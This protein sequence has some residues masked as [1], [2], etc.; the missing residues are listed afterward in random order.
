MSK[1]GIEEKETLDTIKKMNMQGIILNLA[2]GDGRFNNHLLEYADKVIAVDKAASELEILKGNC[3]EHL[4]NKLET[5]VVDITKKLPFVDSTFDG[6][7]CTGFLH[8]FKKEIIANI[9][10]EMK[11]LLKAGGNIILDFATDIKRLDK[12]NNS[13]LFS[14]EGNYTTKEAIAFFKEELID[15]DIDIQVS[16]FREENLDDDAGYKFITGSFLVISG[17]YLNI[18]NISLTL[19][20]KFNIKVNSIE[21]MGEGYDSKSY[22]INNEY[23]F[24][25]AKH[26]D[27]KNSYKREK[28]ILDYLKDNFKSNVNIPRIDYFDESGIM[29]YKMIKG[30][31]LTKEIYESM[32][33]EQKESLHIA[34]ANF[35]KEL[36]NLDATAL[37]EFKNDLIIFYKSDLLLLREKIYSKLTKE[38]QEYIENFI[39][40]IINNKALFQAKKSL[41][42]N[43]LSANHILLDENKKLCGIIDFGDACITEDYRDFMYLLENSE[44][45]IGDHFGEAILDKCDYEFKELARTYAKLNDDY[46]AIETITCGLEN[47]DSSLLEKGLDLLKEKIK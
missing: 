3:P 46:Y 26:D 30:V 20:E 25:L 37:S 39:S 31:P 21:F 19:K 45:E 42:H 44:E 5:Q 34:I 9:V 36:H 2:A 28:K 8:L 29:G 6:I 40:S 11:R 15:F 23:L 10:T 47:D 18:D 4:N 32:N 43:D 16:T 13:V 22:L 33:E 38:E 7:F 24:K 17:T 12:D 1:W 14:E 41:C 35:L 27:A